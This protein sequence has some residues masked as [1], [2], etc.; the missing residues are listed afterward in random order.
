MRLIDREE[1]ARRLDHATCIALVREAM[2]ALAEGRSAQLLRGILD[3]GSGDLFGV[4]PGA[5]GAGFGAKLVSVF[6]GKP[7]SHQGVIAMFDRETGAPTAVIEGGEVTAIRTAC[8]SAAATDA[9]ARRDARTLAILGTGEQAWQHALA[10]PLVRPIEE[11]RIWGRDLARAEALAARIGGHARAAATAREAVAGADVVCT[12]TAAAEPILFSDDVADGTHLNVIGSSHAGPCEIDT[13]LVARARFVP[14]HRAGVLAQGAEFLR[15]RA[16]GLV[17]DDHVLPEIGA[18]YAGTAPG[19]LGDRDVTI[20][21][22]LGSIVQ[23]LAC[24]QWLVR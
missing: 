10:V 20:Y 2:I 23:D 24:A 1:V 15:A 11:I 7:R 6:P 19:R 16:E 18:V 13:A 21:K 4:M 17:G 9:L 22:S 14:D 5:L 3:L 12:T 8:A